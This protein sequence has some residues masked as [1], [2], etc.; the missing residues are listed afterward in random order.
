MGAVFV[1]CAYGLWLVFRD[2]HAF[3]SEDAK[4]LDL[5]D[6]SVWIY[7]TSNF[8]GT[9]VSKAKSLK[10]KITDREIVWLSSGK[11]ESFVQEQDKITFT[12]DGEFLEGKIRKNFHYIDWSDGDCW[13]RDMG[14]KP[15]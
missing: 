10:V 6:E 2:K 15:K 14:T 5:E 11:T 12:Q 3:A 7:S 13:K 4:Q 9:W 1:C 8:M